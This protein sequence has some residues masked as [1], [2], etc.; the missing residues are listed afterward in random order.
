MGDNRKGGFRGGRGGFG[1]F[2]SSGPREM[3][4]ATCAD[5]GQETEVPFQPSGDRPVY[6]RECYQNHRPKR[7]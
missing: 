6:C 4:K 5:C 2:R 7:Y 3:H 1:G